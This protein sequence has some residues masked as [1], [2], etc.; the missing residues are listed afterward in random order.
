MSLSSQ[1]RKTIILE[2]MAGPVSFADLGRRYGVSRE[3]IRQLAGTAGITGREMRREKRD[4]A[5]RAEAEFLVE[6]RERYV[7]PRWGQRIYSRAQFEAFLAETDH[8]LLARWLKAQELPISRSGHA[9]P[10][11]QMCSDCH[12]WK[13]WDEFY[14]DASRTFGRSSRC[15][16]CAKIQTREAYRAGRDS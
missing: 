12:L 13:G 7:P 10:D 9:N 8:A 16:E 2:V 11:N 3:Y 4:N 15:A 6:D 1:A 14:L 5:M